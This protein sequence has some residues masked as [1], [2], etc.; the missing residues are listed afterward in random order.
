MGLLTPRSENERL[1][2][3]SQNFQLRMWMQIRVRIIS[4]ELTNLQHVVMI[5][6]MID[7]MTEIE[8][9]NEV[10]T[11]GMIIVVMREEMTEGAMTEEMTEAPL[12]LTGIEISDQWKKMTDGG[13]QNPLLKNM[14]NPNQ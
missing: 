10:M 5:E 3:N 14:K 12:L 2:R 4:H 6:V 7:E 8:E 9:M 13:P 1:R 11:E